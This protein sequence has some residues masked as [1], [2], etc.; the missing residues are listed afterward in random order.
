MKKKVGRNEP[1]PCGSGKK[2]KKCCERKMI[3]K[4]FMAHKIE[5]SSLASKVSNIGKTGGFSSFF[6]KRVVQNISSKPSSKEIKTE[7]KESGKEPEKI[8]EEIEKSGDFVDKE[9]K[10]SEIKE[11]IDKKKN[12]IED[13]SE[14]ESKKENEIEKKEDISDK[15]SDEENK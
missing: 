7:K 5:G 6:Q 3:G 4:K 9:S 8:E 15:P 13:E 10:D 11:N 12:I 2:F 1:C 14:F